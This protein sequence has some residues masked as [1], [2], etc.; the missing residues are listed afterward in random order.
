QQENLELLNHK[1]LHG[2]DINNVFLLETDKGKFVLKVNDAVRFPKMFEAEAK[3]LQQ[4]KTTKTFKI[5]EVIH[6]DKTE[7]Q[8]YLLLEFITPGTKKIN[9]NDIFGSQLAALH[10]NTAPFFGLDHDNY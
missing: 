6:F 2:G 8:S 9:F 3:G 1:P 7:N 5:P 4:L 10:Q